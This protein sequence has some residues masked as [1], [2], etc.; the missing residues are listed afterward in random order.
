MVLIPNLPDDK[1]LFYPFFIDISRLFLYFPW[2]YTFFVNELQKTVSHFFWWRAPTIL[3]HQHFSAMSVDIF[4]SSVMIFSINIYFFNKECQDIW[5]SCLYLKWLYPRYSQPFYLKNEKRAISK[6]PGHW[7][8][9][10]CCQL[11]ILVSLIFSYPPG[12]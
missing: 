7:V 4:I 12:F 3:F 1:R 10:N 5:F 6:S 11:F 8:P 9:W 2:Q